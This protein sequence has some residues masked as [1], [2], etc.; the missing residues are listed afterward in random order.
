MPEFGSLFTGH[1]LGVNIQVCHG[2]SPR[3]LV[4]GGESRF[5][6][7][8]AL[9]VHLSLVGPPRSSYANLSIRPRFDRLNRLFRDSRR[10]RY[11]LHRPH[12][13]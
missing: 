2:G 7:D 13:G 3:H 10:N 5:H 11:R 8:R 12:G 9:R 4:E 1:R 6:P